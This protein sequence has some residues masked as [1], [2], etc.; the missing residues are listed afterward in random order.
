ML[1][2]IPPDNPIDDAELVRRILG[3]EH[4][5]FKLLVHRNEKLVYSIVFRLIDRKEDREDICQEVFLK[6]FNNLSRFRF[7]SKLS[8]WIGNIAFNQSLN[9]LKRRK[10]MDIRNLYGG[11][12]VDNVQTEI[13]SDI[14]HP[15]QQMME[16]E[17]IILLKN[18]METLNP[19]QKTIIQLFHHL[20]Q[21]LED[22][23]SITGLPVNTVKSH[24]FRA[25]KNLKDEIVKHYRS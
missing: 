25:R 9:F 19:V 6:V 12:E 21:P 17:K 4:N 3:G 1:H 11:S 15:D 20:E 23:A 2:P 18:A 13:I 7:Q 8:T 10:K 5:L 14:I 22:I 16:K 24:L